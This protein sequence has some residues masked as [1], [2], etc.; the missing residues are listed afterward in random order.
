MPIRHHYPGRPNM[1]R[2]RDPLGHWWPD[3]NLH[4]PAELIYTAT[5]LA[6]RF[7]SAITMSTLSAALLN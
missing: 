2:R 5:H 7:G 4:V 3:L 6:H 1:A